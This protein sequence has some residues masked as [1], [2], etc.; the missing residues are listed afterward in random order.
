M[1]YNSR[2]CLGVL[3]GIVLAALL[4]L[5]AAPKGT[6]VIGHVTTMTGSDA[7]IAPGAVPALE[8]EVARV[9]AAGGIN[10]WMLKVISYDGQS[11]PAECV[12]V[13][14]RL[15]DQDKSWPSSAPPSPAP[16]SPSPRSP[17]SPTCRSSPP[18]PP[19]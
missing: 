6:L 11:L 2:H 13:T 7:Y 12:A 18:P 19:T 14:K 9:N 5:S 16:A 8:D 1:K 3:S 4:P 15:I 10:G 17:T